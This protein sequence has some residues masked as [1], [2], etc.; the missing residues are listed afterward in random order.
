LGLVFWRLGQQQKALA[1]FGR[2]L[3]LAPDYAQAY[4]NR[5]L[6]Y[7]ERA[8][9]ALAQADFEQAASLFQAEGDQEGY[10]EAVQQARQLQ[11]SH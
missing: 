7:A 9:K 5:G 2:A 8:E 3:Q 1:E 6:L 4:F 11:E 10:Q